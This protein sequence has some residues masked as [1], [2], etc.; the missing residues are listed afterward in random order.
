MWRKLKSVHSTN[1]E[2][3][4]QFLIFR[5]TYCIRHGTVLNQW[6][7][8]QL[9]ETRHI[10]KH[11]RRSRHS[12]TSYVDVDVKFTNCVAVFIP[13]NGKFSTFCSLGQSWKHQ[14]SWFSH[15]TLLSCISWLLA[16]VLS[17]FSAVLLV[18][19]RIEVN[20]FLF[21]VKSKHT[22]SVFCV[23]VLFQFPWGLAC[24]N[25]R[26]LLALRRWGRSARRNVS[27]P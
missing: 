21:H 27:N 11:S 1:L 5:L 19:V 15:T 10:G 12:R 24:E 6:M 23:Q 16:G 20:S 14:L 17:W 25:I 13:F 8:R 2:F 4:I 7:R 3:Q 9:L 22:V 26:F 18:M